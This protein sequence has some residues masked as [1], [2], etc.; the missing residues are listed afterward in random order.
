MQSWWKALYSWLWKWNPFGHNGYVK[1]TLNPLRQCKISAPLK[2][3]TFLPS[4]E[5]WV[6]QK[7]LLTLLHGCGRGGGVRVSSTCCA[8]NTSR[9]LFWQVGTR[10]CN[11][12]GFTSLAWTAGRLSTTSCKRQL[13]RQGAPHFLSS[14]APW[15]EPSSSSQVIIQIH[16]SPEQCDPSCRSTLFWMC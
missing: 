13:S 9:L 11:S 10:C 1:F 12:L 3:S 2:I 14:S 8:I 6:V 7:P 4:E 5:V 15:Q 16:P